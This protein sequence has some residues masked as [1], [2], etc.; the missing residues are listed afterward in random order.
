MYHYKFREG[1]FTALHDPRTFEEVI[2]AEIDAL[3]KNS[4]ADGRSYLRR[5]YYVDQLVE[6]L[7]Y[8]DRSQFLILEY[9]AYN[10]DHQNAIDQI[11]EFLGIPK[12]LLSNRRV[13]ETD[14]VDPVNYKDALIDLREH[15][16]LKNEMLFQ[17]IGER[18]NW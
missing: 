9:G 12:Q 14:N 17:L 2:E 4:P 16:S 13:N 15:F 8:F 6:Y 7:K 11:C 5:G 10:L 1:A 3:Q 18:Y